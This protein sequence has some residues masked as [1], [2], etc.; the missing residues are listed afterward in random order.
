M[1]TL[2]HVALDKIPRQED[3]KRAEVALLSEIDLSKKRPNTLL[4]VGFSEFVICS[5][6]LL[7]KVGVKA[8]VNARDVMNC[9]EMLYKKNKL[10]YPSNIFRGAWEGIEI[11]GKEYCG[12]TAKK[13]FD[14]LKRAGLVRSIHGRE[15]VLIF[16]TSNYAS[17]D[18]KR[19]FHKN[20]EMACGFFKKSENKKY[21][22]QISFLAKDL[23]MAMRKG[24]VGNE[25]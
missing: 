6:F 2:S 25:W 15:D 24:D 21:L 7:E 19:F 20:L 10:F 3:W 8:L 1:K 9:M 5:F 17:E 12:S 18:A 23:L 4:K 14:Y 22:T 11:D 16:C 13:F